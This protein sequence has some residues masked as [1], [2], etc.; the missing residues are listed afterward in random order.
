MNAII[1]VIVSK[2]AEAAKEAEAEDLATFRARQ[3]EFVETMKDIIY[4][5]DAD[6]DGT[7]S[8]EE[9]QAAQDNED[10]IEALQ[11]VDLPVGF[12]MSELHCMLDK[13]GDG[14]L[15][16]GE[17]GQGMKRLIFSNDFQR[18]CLL[19][20]AVAQQKRKLNQ[21]KIDLE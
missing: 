17:F 11:C 14:E 16:K 5:I 3:M 15:T 13:D 1:G 8:P 6:G 20:L 7:V 19:Q 10:L 12:S 21:L 9:I 18:Q 4:E 2:T